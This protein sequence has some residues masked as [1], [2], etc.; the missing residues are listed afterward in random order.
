MERTS[1]RNPPSTNYQRPKK[2]KFFIWRDRCISYSGDSYA[3]RHG[4]E[5]SPWRWCCTFCNPPT[6]GFRSKQGAWHA[7]M[8][9]SMPRHFAVRQ[10][11]HH[12]AESH[13]KN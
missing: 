11:H 13:A 6:Y 8:T 7:I 4:W 10:G 2:R 1:T 5:R 12:W 3:V 9:I